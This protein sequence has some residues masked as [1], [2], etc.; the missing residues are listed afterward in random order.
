[1]SN[2]QIKVALAQVQKGI[3]LFQVLLITAIISVFVLVAAAYN[4]QV[5]E[6]AFAYKN[7]SDSR[8]RLYSAANEMLFTFLTES[9]LDSGPLAATPGLNYYGKPFQFPAFY[10]NNTAATEDTSTPEILVSLQSADSL[11]DIKFNHGILTTLLQQKG[12]SESAARQ[13]TATL[14][15]AQQFITEAG[16][17]NSINDAYPY[18]PLEAYAELASLPGWSMEI[19]TELLPFIT[20]Y[21]VNANPFWAP[22]DLLP[23]LLPANH[24]EI[25]IQDRQNLQYNAA[26]YTAVTGIDGDEIV[27]FYPDKNLRIVVSEPAQSTSLTLEVKIEPYDRNPVTLYLY[28]KSAGFFVNKNEQ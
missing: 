23:I 19:V 5:L 15:Q 21:G 3:V 2:A 9:W 16:G 4:K 27:G 14:E 28:S 1:M 17:V 18:K 11:L 10:A 13:M 24:A 25:L 8:D 12:L 20:L 7:V 6:Q 22:D 26:R